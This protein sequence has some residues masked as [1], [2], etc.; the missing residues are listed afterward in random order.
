MRPQKKLVAKING[1]RVGAGEH[2]GGP[3]AGG[4]GSWPR[5]KSPFVV[6]KSSPL[7]FHLQGPY[8]YFFLLVT[9]SFVRTIFPWRQKTRVM[10]KE[11]ESYVDNTLFKLFSRENVLNGWVLMCQ[12]LG[13]YVK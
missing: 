7:R 13:V 1:T 8:P 2:M 9:W 3:A 4:W 10:R 6:E 5:D 12:S 11:R